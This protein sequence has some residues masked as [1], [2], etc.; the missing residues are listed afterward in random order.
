MRHCFSAIFSLFFC[1]CWWYWNLNKLRVTF[2]MILISI[3]TFLPTSFFYWFSFLPVNSV[4][5][6]YCHSYCLVS[7]VYLLLAFVLSATYPSY[8]SIKPWSDWAAACSSTSRTSITS[9]TSIPSPS[10]PS[11]KWGSPSTASHYALTSWNINPT[12][13]HHKLWES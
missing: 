12:P 5:Y 6:F 10:R 3:Y 11:D 9:L 4:F 2:L 13:P 1:N 8:I 7:L